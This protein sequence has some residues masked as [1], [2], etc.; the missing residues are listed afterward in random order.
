[1]ASIGST[2]LENASVSIAYEYF[3][4]E[5]GEI[6]GGNIIASINGTI[7]VPDGD[8]GTATGA[9]VMKK[10]AEI[11]KLGQQ[12]KC[13]NVN[14]PGFESLNN[15]G[16]VTSVN[17]EQGPDPAWINQGA[18]SLEVRGLVE[19]IPPNSLGITAADGVTE[20]SRTESLELGEDSH[21]FVFDTSV[22]A[23]K[24]FAKFSNSLRLKCEPFCNDIS[25]IDVLKRVVRTGPS[26]PI[27]ASYSSW[28]KFLHSRSLTINSD[29]SISFNSEIILTPPG[30]NS[31]ALVDLEFGY[32]RAYESKD[33]TYT[34]SGTITGL[35]SVGWSDI[36]SLGDTC[37]A[38]KYANAEG[39]YNAIKGKYGDLNNWAGMTLELE[40]KPNCPKQSNNGIGRCRAENEDD[41]DEDTSYVKPSTSTASGSRTD[42]TINFNF[43]WSTTKN[44]SGETCIKGGVSKEVTVEIIDPQQTYV[45]HTIPGKGTLIQNLNCFSA[46]RLSISITVT[47]QEDSCGELSDCESNEGLDIVYERYLSGGNWLMI[48][49]KRTQTLN[50]RTISQ[51]FILCRSS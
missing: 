8:E 16:K 51:D 24:A 1:M 42:G 6:I 33:I 32:S 49:D 36:V 27:F 3:K 5:G 18:Y 19:R 9:I 17:I 45:E 43:E 26:N 50:S 4:T 12:T 29:N 39:V 28:N 30:T 47:A 21:D 10:L 14:I 11:R 2:T 41:N 25:P 23:S 22:G 15:K 46:P 13:I 20:I 31:G 37:A 48:S 35:V 38:S 7:T 40:E 44:E 34:T